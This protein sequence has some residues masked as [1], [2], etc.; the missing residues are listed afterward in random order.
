[1]SE[2]TSAFRN[3][4]D[5]GSASS[6]REK[7]GEKEKMQKKYYGG[8]VRTV[9]SVVGVAGLAGF[10]VG[11]GVNS[12]SVPVHPEN[13]LGRL[14]V[15]EASF[16][17]ASYGPDENAEN[18]E[19]T[20]M[21]RMR[22]SDG[23]RSRR[24]TS[25]SRP[26]AN[27]E[28]AQEEIEELGYE[29]GHEIGRQ[30]GGAWDSCK[31]QWRVWLGCETTADKAKRRYKFVESGARGWFSELRGPNHQRREEKRQILDKFWPKL[32]AIVFPLGGFLALVVLLK[33]FQKIFT[34]AK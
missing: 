23:A 4:A 12:P 10:A 31:R 29:I 13:S 14:G 2:N 11:Q 24:D 15:A 26:R 32:W 18:A 22:A 3:S 21:R 33:L 20:G 7:K 1:M 19:S 6:T 34:K 28:P 30:A 16:E 8:L 25:I 17:M 27:E 5:S 9:I